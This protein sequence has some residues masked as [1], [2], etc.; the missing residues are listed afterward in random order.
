VSNAVPAPRPGAAATGILAKGQWSLPPG[1]VVTRIEVE[2][3]TLN[4]GTL[5]QTV[6]K[7]SIP[8]PAK[9]PNQLSD[10][11]KQIENPS[12][13]GI[14][15]AFGAGTYVVTARLY[16]KKFV[17]GIERGEEVAKDSD[18]IVVIP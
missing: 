10:Y 9:G 14:A 16:R 17:F 11:S 13:P 3:F 8:N 12:T 18:G 5:G 2:V 4:N 6:Y 7:N 1:D 15:A